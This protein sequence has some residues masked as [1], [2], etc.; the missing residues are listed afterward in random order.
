MARGMIASFPSVITFIEDNFLMTSES[1]SPAE[2]LDVNIQY[3]WRLDQ[4]GQ[5]EVPLGRPVNAQ[6]QTVMVYCS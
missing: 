1:A 6:T 4:H 5:A 3:V 2:V